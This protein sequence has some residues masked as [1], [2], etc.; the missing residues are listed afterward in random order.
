MNYG[1]NL[2]KSLEQQEFWYC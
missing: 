2:A 1:R